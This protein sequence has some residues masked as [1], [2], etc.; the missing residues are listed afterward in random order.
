VKD[1]KNPRPVLE[2][3]YEKNADIVHEEIIIDEETGSI[4]GSV[5]GSV[6]TNEFES[7]DERTSKSSPE[8]MDI[9][10]ELENRAPVNKSPFVSSNGTNTQ[11]PRKTFAAPLPPSNPAIA[12]LNELKIEQ[13]GH[14]IRTNISP[15]KEAIEILDDLYNDLDNDY[16]ENPSSSVSPSPQRPVPNNDE[17]TP[18]H[19]IRDVSTEFSKPTA[20]KELPLNGENG[21]V[22]Q[23]AASFNVRQP[24]A[25]SS[26]E[27]TPKMQRTTV[28]VRN[29]PKSSESPS[30]E[31]KHSREDSGVDSQEFAPAYVPPPDPP[32]DYEARPQLKKTGNSINL[33][34][35]KF[36]LESKPEPVQQRRVSDESTQPTNGIRKQQPVHTN[37]LLNRSVPNRATVTRKTRTYVVDGV[38]V[39]S[40]SLHVLG[41][42]QDYA[43]RKKELQELKRL[44]RREA[45]DQQLLNERNEL[46]RDMQ[47]RKFNEYRAVSQPTMLI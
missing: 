21:R 5:G 40:T 9:D 36:V 26:R 45:R 37:N 22:A 23:I 46:D 15:G 39:T 14:S 13:H 43:L 18:T 19:A 31:Q 32:I 42:Q 20:P 33:S 2:L 17:S 28:E 30:P 1:A 35:C 44:Q 3:L 25:Q 38:E 6:L 41:A 47:E 7:S 16:N 34:F 8:R 27:T 29:P 11:L 24:S 12:P 10:T 4:D